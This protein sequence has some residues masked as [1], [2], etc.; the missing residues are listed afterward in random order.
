[1]IVLLL[2]AAASPALSLTVYDKELLYKV[3]FG[4]AA[5]V[6]LLLIKGADANQLNE[7]GMP[8]V[9][10]AASRRDG[11]AVPILRAL[12]AAKADI[13]QG[14]TSRQY[15]IVLAARA[16]DKELMKFLLDDAYADF[17]VRDMNGQT[18]REI[19]SYYGFT[20]V[21]AMID[22]IH[23]ER[24]SALRDMYSP[25]RREQLVHDAIYHYCATSYLYFYFSTKQDPIPADEQQEMLELHKGQVT[26]AINDLAQ[27]FQINGQTI[28]TLG[29]EAGQKVAAEME[30]L[31]SNRNRRKHGVGTPEDLEKRCKTI[32]QDIITKRIDF[33]VYEDPTPPIGQ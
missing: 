3:R 17:N 20:E 10:V 27:I 21:A 4:Q 26:V 28:M 13:D 30:A 22:A 16:G 12:V 9:S 25:E 18:P 8:L 5:D 7:V 23:D 11:Q 29:Q 24:A 31:I 32:T 15:P 6:Q 19:A 33:S 14:G 1:M 2:F